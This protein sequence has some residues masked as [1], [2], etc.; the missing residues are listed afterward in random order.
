MPW[1]PDPNWISPWKPY[2]PASSGMLLQWHCRSWVQLTPLWS[3]K[4]WHLE[5]P[6]SFSSLHAYMTLFLLPRP[7]YCTSGVLKMS[8]RTSRRRI[9]V[10][11]RR[12]KGHL[13][14]DFQCP[15]LRLKPPTNTL[16]QTLQERNQQHRIVQNCLST[17]LQLP[18][19]GVHSGLIPGNQLFQGSH[20]AQQ[21]LPHTGRRSW[22]EKQLVCQLLKPDSLKVSW[23]DSQM[24]SISIPWYRALLVGLRSDFSML[25]ITPTSLHSWRSCLLSCNKRGTEY[26]IINQLPRCHEPNPPLVSE[27]PRK[28][29]GSYRKA[30]TDN[31][32]LT[33]LPFEHNLKIR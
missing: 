7:N 33:D 13:E 20:V 24:V 1:S 14:G 30:E 12:R 11:K 3:W 6:K 28:D 29:L 25:K 22:D 10:K 31:P 19:K 4:G 5:R 32:G 15:S 18:L 9:G 2:S 27:H 23:E 17:C 16:P 26:V 8:T 21:L